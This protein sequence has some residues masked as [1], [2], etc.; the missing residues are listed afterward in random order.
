MKG[1]A[2]EPRIGT[3][4][5]RARERMR[6]TQ[7]QL[8]DALGVSVRT[9][10]DWEND[11]AYPRSSIGALEE[12]L[13]VG[14]D[15]PPEPPRIPAGLQRMIDALTDDEREALLAELTGRPAAPAPRP[16]RR[17]SA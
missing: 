9:V 12:V 2:T 17:E 14:L 13:G 3:K 8:A 4:V 6:W 7:K 16:G 1:M 5:R 11:R 15:G 10:N